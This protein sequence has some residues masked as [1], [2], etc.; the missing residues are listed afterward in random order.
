MS[1]FFIKI[2][3]ILI[4]LFS[5]TSLASALT[6]EEAYYEGA[7]FTSFI[8]ASGIEY[9]IKYYTRLKDNQMFV[10]L[11]E[12][13]DNMYDYPIDPS[14]YGK[15]YF[16]ITGYDAKDNVYTVGHR[17][18]HSTFWYTSG[19]R[20]ASISADAIITPVVPTEDEFYK[21]SLRIIIPAEDGR[22]TNRDYISL[23][24]QYAIPITESNI[25]VT[26][27]GGT[28]TKPESNKQWEKDGYL[29]CEANVH[30]GLALG[31][32]DITVILTTDSRTLSDSRL[33]IRS[34]FVDEDGDGWDDNTGE[35]W[36]PSPDES[37]WGGV[38]QPPGED[39]TIFDYIK[40]LSDSLV[41]SMNQMLVMLRSFMG[42]LA[43]L[44]QLFRSFFSFMPPQFSAIILLGLVM[45]V[46]LRVVGR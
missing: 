43:Q 30:V 26:I 40:Y 6:P 39:A 45:A 2:L 21:D 18:W 14:G 37:D 46:I 29:Y 35:G 28:Y 34:G 22:K 13:P 32:N 38:P 17:Y 1:K 7:K 41:Y 24:Y 3:L 15:A 31:E 36:W 5:S 12:H 42:G 20:W 16:Y 33:V 11:R 25:N 23:W 8:S 27:T 9:R 4:F 19:V 44:G 10:S